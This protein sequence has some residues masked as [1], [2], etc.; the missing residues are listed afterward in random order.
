MTA[1]RW[2]TILLRRGEDLTGPT[3]PI[4]A[5]SAWVDPTAPG[6]LAAA[7]TAPGD[8]SAGD[9]VEWQGQS[10]VAGEPRVG[11]GIQ[12]CLLSPSA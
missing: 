12:V 11:Q 8:L 3:G 1:E 4:R 10:F 2:R 9:A 7:A 6:S 5:L